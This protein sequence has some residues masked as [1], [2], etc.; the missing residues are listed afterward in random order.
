M[1]TPNLTSEAITDRELRFTRIFDAPRSLVFEVW[2]NPKHL[3]HWWGPIGFTLTSL[4]HDFR[5]GGHWKFIMHG[6]DGTDYHNRIKYHEIAKPQRLV[7]Q[8]VG[9]ENTEPIHFKVEVDFV[10]LDKRTQVHMH[11]IFESAAELRHVAEKY[12]AIEGAHQ[13]LSRNFHWGKQCGSHSG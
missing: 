11:M 4:E 10:E 13:T 8:H 7:Y 5:P 1:S 6:P 3:A 9:A 2:T 12:G